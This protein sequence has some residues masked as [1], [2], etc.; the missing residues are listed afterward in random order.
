MVEVIFTIAAFHVCLCLTM[1]P[2]SFH[3]SF[4]REVLKAIG[5]VLCIAGLDLKLINLL[6]QLRKTDIKNFWH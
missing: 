3:E 2:N 4:K 1:L 6:D 5:A